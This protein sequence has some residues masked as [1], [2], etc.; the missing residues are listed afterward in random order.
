M[1]RTVVGID[2]GIVNVGV[3]KWRE[4]DS[5][6]CHL[7]KSSFL[8]TADGRLYEYREQIA[9]EL[10]ENWVK[11]RWETVFKG[12]DIVLIEKQLIKTLNS[13]ERACV[14]IEGHLKM[15]FRRE[16]EGPAYKVITP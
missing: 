8:L 6:P 14:L 3:C 15:L 12:A 16:K 2:I 10:V 7:E 11:D 13:T 1:S 4:G 5:Q 9:E